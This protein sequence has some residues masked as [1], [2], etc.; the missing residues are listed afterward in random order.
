MP[1]NLIRG[2]EESN[3]IH[4]NVNFAFPQDK[5]DKPQNRKKKKAAHAPLPKFP[6]VP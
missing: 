1:E 2:N 3:K 6:A 5:A 4:S